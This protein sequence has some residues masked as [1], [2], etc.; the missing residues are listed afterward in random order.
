VDQTLTHGLQAAK[1]S[2][3]T[4]SS[5]ADSDAISLRIESSVRFWIA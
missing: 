4:P 2:A 1:V 3:I 5:V